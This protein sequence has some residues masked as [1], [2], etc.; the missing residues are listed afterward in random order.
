MDACVRRLLDELSNHRGIEQAHIIPGASS[1]TAQVCLHY[2]PTILSLG[3]VRELVQSTG[4]RITEQYGHFV[5]KVSGLLHQRQAQRIAAYLRTQPGVLEA[6]AALGGLVRVE[7]DRRETSNK[8]LAEMLG[9]VGL[10]I[11]RVL[12][13]DGPT[14]NQR[15]DSHNQDSH[16]DHDYDGD[17]DHDHDKGAHDHDH[18]GILGANTELYFALF[19]GICLGAGFLLEKLTQ[20]PS[21]AS[22]ALY[23][24]AYGFGGFYT[25][26][27]A[28]ENLR[29]KRFEIDTLMLVAAAGAAGLGEWAEGALL[30]FLFSI[31]HALEGFAMGRARRAIEALATLAPQTAEVIREDR[32]VE[33][34]V[35]ELIVGDTVVARPNNRIPADGFI[36]KGRSSV[37]Q[38]PITG[39]SVPVDK[40]PV[41]ERERASERPDS[42]ASQHRVFAGTINGTG[43]LEIYVTRTASDNTLARVVKMVSEAETQKSPTQR[44][45]DRFERI[46]VPVILLFVGILLFAWVVVD[47]P[48]RDSFYRAMAVLV[49]ASPCALAIATPSAVLSGVARAA[50]G[51]VL[52]KGGAPLENLGALTAI[53][54]DKT[55]TLT[56]GKPQVT[57]AVAAHGVDQKELL[58]VAAA[59][60]RQSDHPLAAAVVKHAE[61]RLGGLSELPVASGVTGIVGRGVS[62]IIGTEQVHI[63]K[64]DLFLQS[65]EVAIPGEIRNIVQ[66]LELQGRTTMIVRKGER[67]LGVIGLMD[68]PRDAAR[69]VIQQLRSLGINRMIMLSGDNNLVAEA[70]STEVGL[71]EA[72]GNLMPEDKVETIKK[73]RAEQKVAMVGDGVNDAPALAT[74]DVGIAMGAAG[75]DVALETADVALMA[76]DLTKLPFA[77]G[78]SRSTRRVIR[79]NLWV[80]LGMVALL[81]P[82]T[83]FGLQIGLAVLLHEGSTLI[84]VANALRLL[85]YA[86][87]ERG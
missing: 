25:L 58:K 1:Q 20:A 81:I 29:L 85:A 18:G 16:K 56:E 7:F 79:Q 76:D 42:V 26:R 83:V 71:N 3:R 33:I 80:S 28:I 30:L 82:A 34:P 65:L 12:G 31:G 40:E 9:R 70:V 13:A 73:L 60:E 39:E 43:A 64:K 2:D 27:E 24:A 37:N 74:A 36:L 86:G 61:E 55:G 44:L 21:W 8:A 50:R 87:G 72:F 5:W 78:L 66:S 35:E 48:F 32:V 22:L 4:A 41:A 63:G 23:V 11:N 45:T 49:A 51:G 69:T 19:C 17:R 75:S 59:V 77:V 62:A 68:K 15:R 10:R 57:D 46:F 53:A 54:F 47:E 84:V 38:A 52:V 14:M 6:E 67:Y